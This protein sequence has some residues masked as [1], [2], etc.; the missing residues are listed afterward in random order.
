[1]E[2]VRKELS[3]LKANSAFLLASAFPSLTF[4][5]LTSNL[6]C[7][8]LQYVRVCECVSCVASCVNTEKAGWVVLKAVGRG[9]VEGFCD[10]PWNQGEGE[11]MFIWID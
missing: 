6:V 4:C 5:F 11:R 10:N 2:Q 7:D 8:T 9:A 1:M 3:R